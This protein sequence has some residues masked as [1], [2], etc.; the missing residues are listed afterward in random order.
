MEYVKDTDGKIYKVT[1]VKE[2]VDLEGLKAELTSLQTLV[3]NPE[4]SESELLEH[5]RRT[6]PFFAERDFAL[7]RIIE[8]E[9]IL[10]LYGDNNI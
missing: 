6:H 4:P 10:D 7:A 8:I 1:Q 3:D 9:G 2:E 5:A